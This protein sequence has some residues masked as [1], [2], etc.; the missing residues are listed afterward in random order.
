L[1]D[2]GSPVGRN[3]GLH[4]N[5]LEVMAGVGRS[6]GLNQANGILLR[7]TTAEGVSTP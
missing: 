3:K 5:I 6:S 4:T 1:E 7:V 2:S